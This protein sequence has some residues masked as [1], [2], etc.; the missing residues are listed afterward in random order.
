[1]TTAAVSP[2]RGTALAA[3]SGTLTVLAWLLMA[4]GGFVR[5][6]ESGLGCPDWPACHGRLVAGGH[7][8]LIEE[9]HRWIAT[10]LILGI[11]GLLFAAWHDRGLRRPMLVVAALLVVQVVL[12]G[13]TVLLNNVSW[14]VVAHYGTAAL[15]TAAL[16]FVAVRLARPE[17]RAGASPRLVAVFAGSAFVLLLLGSTVATTDSHTACGQ[18][19]P[20]CNG[21]LAPALD[22]HVA[23]NLAHRAVAGAMLVFAVIVYLR[24]RHTAALVV[25]GLF[26]VQAAAGAAVVAVGEN[27]AVEVTHSAIA[28]LTWLATATLFAL[29]RTVARR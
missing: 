26:V 16:V 3:W 15:L 11:A 18:G 6:S 28:S 14:T 27:T 2:T 23:I 12:G 5:A 20:L 19:F 8:A 22:H 24:T 10:V 17:E 29:S 21:S 25:L 4:V 1:V 7:H 9:V 13:V